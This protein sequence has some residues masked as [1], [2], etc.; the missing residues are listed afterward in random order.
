V[1]TSSSL[2]VPIKEQKKFWD[3][4]LS[5]DIMPYSE[6]VIAALD[7]QI[8]TIDTKI[9][10]EIDS[11]EQIKSLFDTVTSVSGVG[12]QTAIQIIVLGG[13]Q[14]N[15]FKE[16]ATARE[17]ACYIDGHPLN[18]V[19]ENLCEGRQKYHK[20]LIKR[21]KPYLLWVV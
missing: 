13:T 16:F 1:L 11:D 18:L 15:E 12:K 9:K 10:A 7:T 3:S 17:F 21:L 4:K 8:A 2:A 6:K 19:Q 14:T 5:A 20:K